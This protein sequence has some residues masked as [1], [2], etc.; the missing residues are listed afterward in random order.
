MLTS[1]QLIEKY[2]LKKHPEG[3]HFKEI[4]RD[5]T[6][7]DFHE[8][9]EGGTRNLLTSIYFLLKE[10]EQSALHV[11]KNSH[12][13]WYHHAG[14]P[15]Q[16][17]MVDPETGLIEKAIVGNPAEG[18][19][20]HYLVP[21][22]QW[23][24]AECI[25]KTS[26]SFVS[27]AVVP[28]FDY[29][30]FSFITEEQFLKIL[31]HPPSEV[32]N[33]INVKVDIHV[34][35]VIHAPIEKVWAIISDFNGL[36]S[37]HPAILNSIIEPGK[38]NNEVGCIRNFNLKNNGGNIRE[39]LVMFTPQDFLVKYKILESPMHLSNYTA[40]LQLEHLGSNEVKIIWKCH[41]DC[42]LKYQSSLK[43]IIGNHVF[44]AGFDALKQ[45]LV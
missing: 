35:D 19:Q 25:D 24:G 7:I 42:H 43:E 44:Q 34:D 17:T 3:G 18:Y 26:Y 6:A 31:P 21:G 41:F 10:E 20:P 4:Y 15:L 33:L 14:S 45:Q 11:I 28:G 36:P 9:Y 32:L 37:W 22:N 12:E 27:C 1:Q 38:E 30:D 23:F 39:E 8:K 40:T 29:R 13:I 16:I 2:Q 5:N